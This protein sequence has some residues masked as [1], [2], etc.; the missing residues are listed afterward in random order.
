[1]HKTAFTL[2]LSLILSALS[3]HAQTTLETTLDWKVGPDTVIFNETVSAIPTGYIAILNTSVGEFDRQVMDTQRSVLEWQRKDATE[4]T[5]I[6]AVRQGSKVTVKGTYKGKP[7]QKTHDF[8]NQAWYQLQ[9]A[10]YE[11]LYKSGVT[12]AKFWSI[13][14][15][16]LSA[17]EF[18]AEKMVE[19]NILIM[20]KQI[21]AVKYALGVS[22][23]P[24]FL[25][26][27]YFWL[28]KADG[29]FLKLEAPAVLGVPKS[30]IELTSEKSF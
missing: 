17:T 13:D 29:R 21:P 12:N 4:G 5:D 27:A 7:Y 3:L 26:Q 15:K 25:F 9:E 23:V 28:R 18:K 19:E 10:S 30:A 1:M 11:E 2:T 14:R 24:A 6:Q 20:G 8:G 22:G 16:R